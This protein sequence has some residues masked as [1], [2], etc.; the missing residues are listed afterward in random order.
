MPARPP[1]PPDD[2]RDAYER[3][4]E[5]AAG[6]ANRESR[7][8]RDIGPIPPVADPFRKAAA[9]GAFASF[10]RTYF[11][12]RF[13]LAWSPDHHKVIAKIERAVGEGGT[14]AVAM[15]RGSGKTTLVEVACAWALLTG[16]RRF[17][18][19]VGAEADAAQ[20]LLDSLKVELETNEV[21]AED[22]P[23]ACY[24][25]RRLEG[26]AQRARGQLSQGARTHVT[27]EADELRLAW[28]PGAA[29]S[30]GIV[31]AAGIL[32]RL[33]GAKRTLADGRS[34][35]PDL[36]VVDDPQTDESARSPSQCL[37]RLGV[38]TKA[39]LGLAGPGAKIAGIM[40]CTVIRPG[41]LADRVLDPARHPEWQGERCR[42]VYAW[43][44]DRDRWDEYARLRREGMRTGEGSG[45]CTAYYLAN[46]AAM[47]AGAIVAWPERH[48]PDE[49]SAVQHVMN[50]LIDRGQDYVDAE[51]QNAP[52]AAKSAEL[53]MLTADEIAALLSR[54][55]QGQAPAAAAKVT[56]FIDVQQA[57]LFWLVCGWDPGFGGAV[58]DYGTWPPQRVR[59]FDLAS[60]TDT[61]QAR[62]PGMPLEAQLYGALDQCAAE[63][64]AREWERE[65]GTALRLSKCL[66]DANWGQSTET[67]YKLCRRSPHAAILLPSHG[68]GVGPDQ[69]PI[70]RYRQ[71]PGEQLGVEWVVA[72]RKGQEHATYDTNWWKSF[73]EARLRTPD[74][75]AGSLRLWGDEAS[76]HQ[77]LASHLAA[78]TR[79]RTEGRG[80]VVDVWRL[81]PERPDNHWLDGL[82]GAAVAASIAGVRLAVG[83]AAPKPKPRRRGKVSSLEC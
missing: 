58:L 62:F 64:A 57:V 55:D 44:T 6:R 29:C 1:A 50:L 72:G 38:V 32:G 51:L 10:A 67:V 34:V 41:D 49:A 79:T 66:V 70:S 59:W 74:G 81:R 73:V 71:K 24:P 4:R 43:P 30:G 8:G 33:R 2:D 22:Y 52:Q 45:P 37:T 63:L 28:L 35:R 69:V 27:W 21:L 39:V 12:H 11:P 18:F 15:P 56:A 9:A 7:S 76:A 42:A 31:K 13:P 14:F 83:P 54:L 82:V 80:R 78:E 53:P 36:V 26:I 46:R 40:P 48:D 16:R 77:L 47:D 3:H 60:L 19:L 5:R 75:A 25:V 20:E 17:V 65:D 61:I 23:E 68:R